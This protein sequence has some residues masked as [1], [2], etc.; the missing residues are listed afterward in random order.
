[1]VWKNIYVKLSDIDMK[2]KY[3]Q[4]KLTIGLDNK[5]DKITNQWNHNFLT[6]ILVSMVDSIHIYKYVDFSSKTVW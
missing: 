5:K 4:K 6:K 2:R 1:M 3:L